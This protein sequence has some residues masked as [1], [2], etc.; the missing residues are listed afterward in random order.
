VCAAALL[1]LIASA[2]VVLRLLGTILPGAFSPAPEGSG[3][4]LVRL[5]SG[6]LLAA[7]AFAIFRFHWARRG[8]GASAAGPPAP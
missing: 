7:G 2:P 5:V 6:G 1:V 8:E 4:G 3:R